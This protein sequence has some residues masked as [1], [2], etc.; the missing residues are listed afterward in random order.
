MTFKAVAAIAAMGV[1]LSGCASSSDDIAAAYVS[2]LAYDTYTCPQLSGELQRISARVHEVT[3][4]VDQKATNDKV[5]MGVGLVLF[6]PALFFLKGNGPE[7]EELARLKGE[8][9]AVNQE[10][11]K[12]NC[13]PIV[14][15]PVASAAAP[16]PAAAALP[17]STTAAPRTTSA[18]PK[19][20]GKSAN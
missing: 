16:S 14:S 17:V 1:A 18:S 12:D 6:W 5:A 3:G 13:G 4:T 20:A 2:P 9:D 19:P 7:Q 11:I 15:A 10:M 8:Y